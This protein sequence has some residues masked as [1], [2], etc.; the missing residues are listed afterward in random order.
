M[1]IRDDDPGVVP[2]FAADDLAAGKR[3]DS[4][5]PGLEGQPAVDPARFQVREILARQIR[6][7]DPG[8]ASY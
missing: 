1:K 6:P 5:Q 7:D 2:S 8:G 4:P 3:I